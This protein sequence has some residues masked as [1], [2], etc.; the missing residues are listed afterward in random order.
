MTELIGQ[1]LGDYQ[2]EALI[3][4]GRTGAL[5]RGRHLRLDRPTAIQ[6]FA[7]D[8]LARPGLQPRLLATLRAVAALRHPHIVAVYDIV[9]RDGQLFLASELP[10]GGNLRSRMQSGLPLSERL[11]LVAQAADG[12]AYAHAAGIVHGAL[13]PELLLH[14]IQPNAPVPLLKL[15][16]LG[17]ASLL[18][19][20]AQEAPAYLSPEQARGLLPEP[21]SDLYSLG[22][23][24]Y[25]LLV[26]VPPFNVSNLEIAVAKHLRTNPVPPRLVRPQIPVL[27]ETLVL[28]C[29]AKTAAD[30]PPNALALADDVRRIAGQLGP[31]AKPSI[32]KPI[33][34]TPPQGSS[35]QTAPEDDLLAGLLKSSGGG[36]T[37]TRSTPPLEVS[38]PQDRIL[39]TPGSPS[40]VPIRLSNG[41]QGAVDLSLSVDGVPRSWLGP[42]TIALF[43]LEPGAQM[44]T[45]LM[46]TVPRDHT[47]TAGDYPVVVRA[48]SIGA[49]AVT[50][51]ARMRWT[52]LP[53]TSVDLQLTPSHCQS[54]AV[55]DFQIALHNVGNTPTTCLLSFEDDGSLGFTLAQDEILLNP[56]ETTRI[57]LSVEAAQRMFGSSEARHFAIKMVTSDGRSQLAEA[58]LVHLARLPTW[59]P[60][61]TLSLLFLIAL[62]VTVGSFFGQR[63]PISLTPTP[64]MLPATATPFPTPLPGAPTILEFRIQPDLTAPGEVVRVSWSV[65]GAERV[66]I[67]RFGDVPAQGAREFRPEQT[68]EFRLV[69]A[70]AGRE[71]VAITYVNVAPATPTSSPT[72][73]PTA[74]PTTEPTATPTTE[75]TATPTTE[76]TATPTT[77]PTATLPPTTEPTAT[78]PPEATTTGSSATETTSA[79]TFTVIDLVDLAVG[80]SWSTNNGRI[81]FGRPL[82]F[83]NRGGWANLTDITLED[84]Q[85][86]RMTLQLVPP[87]AWLRGEQ[88]APYIQGELSLPELR[89]GQM[90]TAAV[91]FAQGASSEPLSITLLIDEQEIFE[92]SKRPDGRL[93]PISIDLSRYSGQSRKLVLRVSGL[94]D[95]SIQGLFWVNPR[96]E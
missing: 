71:T 22:V 88:P 2:L 77:E 40:V 12:L 72:T 61:A 29:L 19:E 79:T 27:L 69:A 59:M 10:S 51:S 26:G 56:G 13:R 45:S 38:L 23:L 16:G 94:A 25:E 24:L 84:G 74:T 47:T 37:P 68:T 65:Q 64:T 3:A 21:Q 73:E 81:S 95:A 5:Y 92:A 87:A 42:E 70:S 63:D 1:R 43:R 49:A 75:P 4:S 15:S 41:G 32:T 48:Q 18:P 62:A 6:T 11:D 66:T 7:A 91:G 33:Q 90:L 8:L 9:H 78:L 53:F 30:R 57:A 44:T 54:Y 36:V 34:I 93:L 50:S 46:V 55:A 35:P 39:L 20:F 83:A 80:A 67:D 82:F 76:P 60:L 89:S 28:R 85:P 52:V 17:I 86:Q 58:D 96:I 14:E 31:L